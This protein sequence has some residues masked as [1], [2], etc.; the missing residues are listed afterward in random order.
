MTHLRFPKLASVFAAA[1][2]A[3]A[4]AAIGQ[5]RNQDDQNYDNN[6]SRNNQN[7]DDSQGDRDRDRDQM[8]RDS[9]WDDSQ[10][11]N[12][13]QDDRWD[14]SNRDQQRRNQQSQ[15]DD[16]NRDFQQQGQSRGGLG[17]SVVNTQ[18]GVRVRDVMRNSPAEQ[19]GIEQGDQIVEVD[20]TRINGPEQLVR[21]VSRA[22]P[23]EQ[24][25]IR[26][27][28]DGQEQTVRARL[29]SRREALNMDQRRRGDRMGQ[30]ERFYRGGTPPW[31]GDDLRNRVQQLDRQVEM[32]RREIRDLRSMIDDDPSGRDFSNDDSQN[33]F[34]DSQRRGSSQYDSGRSRNDDRNQYQDQQ[35]RNRPQY[36]DRN[37]D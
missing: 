22:N 18:R 26:L 6:Q 2:I 17:I 21:V 27:I 20:N 29:E 28:R 5:Q 31:S 16:R 7:Y 19:A 10:Q 25:E 23:G 33:R 34:D 37:R 36:D 24:V 15:Y 9:Q 3:I 4:G 8:Q 1:S 14:D 35:D 11:N 12:R 30:T 13:R 32:L